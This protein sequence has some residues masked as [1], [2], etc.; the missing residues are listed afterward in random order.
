MKHELATALHV[1]SEFDSCVLY[2]TQTYIKFGVYGIVNDVLHNEQY[3]AIPYINLQHI[4]YHHF[5][6]DTGE[7]WATTIH[8]W[9][10]YG[11][12]RGN[13]KDKGEWT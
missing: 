10:S 8:Y 11:N 1:H 9:Q 6:G 5:H 13:I 7:K 2:I 12:K 4:V 3:T